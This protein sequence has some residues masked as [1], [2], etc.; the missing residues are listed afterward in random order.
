MSALEARP[1]FDQAAS[2]LRT[3]TALRSRPDPMASDDVGCHVAAMCAQVVEKSI[4]GYVIVNG[5]T[6]SL[7]HRPDKYLS[8]LLTK[9]N[10]LLRYGD[11]YTHLSKLFDIATKKAVNALLELTPGGQGRRTDAPNT[12][13]PWQVAGAWARTPAGSKQFAGGRIDE[14]LK[15]ARRVQT[16]LQKLEIAASRDV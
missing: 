11:H 10:P 5:S 15:L 14:M 9:G 8:T 2:D 13:Y 12:E 7:D 4:K 1:W 3:A 16:T 6:P